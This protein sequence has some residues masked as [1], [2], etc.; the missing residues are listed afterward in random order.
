[1]RALPIVKRTVLIASSLTL[2]LAVITAAAI[3]A[4]ARHE[5]ADLRAAH[6]KSKQVAPIFMAALLATEPSLLDT[7]RLSLGS[8]IRAFPYRSGCAPTLAFRLVRSVASQEQRMWRWHVD[9]AITT[10]IVTYIFTP[11]D[12]LRI[13][14]REV[15][16]GEVNGI[17]LY[18]LEA[19]ARGYLR[20]TPSDLTAGEAALLVAMLPYPNAFS[21]FRH[22]ARATERRNRVLAEMR[23][24]GYLDESRFRAA[25]AEALPLPGA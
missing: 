16:F 15:Y 20:K 3:W 9:T 10:V 5:V 8:F 14:A 1:M 6:A 13:Y 4:V 7:H 22:P 12:M 24:R 11:E 19:A 2:V 17:Q 23:R 25:T 18:G 21:P